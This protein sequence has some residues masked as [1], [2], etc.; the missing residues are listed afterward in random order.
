MELTRQIRWAASWRQVREL[1]AAAAPGSL[2]EVHLSTAATRLRAVA[3][4]GQ[5]SASGG[6]AAPSS[7]V[8]VEDDPGRGP[9][10]ARSQRPS[11]GGGRGARSGGV[12]GGASGSRA[13]KRER[14]AFRTFVAGVTELCG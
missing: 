8:A 9:G 3:P 10:A 4:P 6:S 11:G 13:A 2:D 7:A 12:G 1:L 5:A 14:A